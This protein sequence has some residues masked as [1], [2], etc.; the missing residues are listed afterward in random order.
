MVTMTMTKMA[1]MTAAEVLL[2]LLAKTDMDDPQVIGDE[3][4][5][6]PGLYYHGSP[7]IN[8]AE[9]A[10]QSD[11]AAG[12]RS[13]I[14]FSQS[15]TYAAMYAATR[16]NLRGGRVYEV[17]LITNSA[18]TLPPAYWAG[19]AMDEAHEESVCSQIAAQGHDCIIS[20]ELNGV[21]LEV[22][23][24]SDAVIRN[25]G[26][27]DVAP[28]IKAKV[29][30]GA[31]HFVDGLSGEADGCCRLFTCGTRALAIGGEHSRLQKALLPVLN[32]LYCSASTWPKLDLD[33]LRQFRFDCLVDPANGEALALDAAKV[34][35]MNR[36]DRRATKTKIHKL[37][38][39]YS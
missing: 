34:R 11:L 36:A 28:K 23:V 7:R 10:S 33:V 15:P 2:R 13:G 29:A 22:I 4:T 37:K 31:F 16:G 35:P 17:E 19:N 39:A 30:A 5:M 27:G 9:F 3:P 12:I 1:D 20:E 21:V 32:P 18:L 6:T 25:R 8:L 38:R 14:Y 24:F 26:Q